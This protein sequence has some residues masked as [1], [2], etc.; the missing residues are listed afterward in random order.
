M[1]KYTCLLLLISLSILYPCILRSQD[2]TLDSL[3]KVLQ[4]QGE[5]TNRANTLHVISYHLLLQANFGEA[6]V[7]ATNELSL[8]KKLGFKKGMANASWITAAVYYNQS[9]YTEAINNALKSLEIKKELNDKR[10]T[11]LLYQMLS[12]AN[13][14]IGNYGENLQYSYESLRIQEE[15]K[16]KEGIAHQLTDLANT[17]TD[18][19]NYVEGKKNA[20]AGFKLSEEIKDTSSMIWSRGILSLIDFKDGKLNE[21]LDKRLI[22]IKI[23]EKM[24]SAEADYF[25]ADEYQYTGKIY[26]K[27]GDQAFDTGNE[28]V[29]AGYFA[30]AEKNYLLALKVNERN[31]YK[32]YIASVH[33]DLA[34]INIKFKKNQAAKEHLQQSLALSKA[35]GFKNVI[36]DSYRSLSILDSL[37]GNYKE[38]YTYYKLYILYRDSIHSTEGIGKSSE[39]KMQYALEKKEAESKIIQ[40]KKDAEAKLVRNIQYTAI[41]IFLLV[42]IFLYWNNHQKQK[43][44]TRIEQAYKEL[45]STQAQLIQSEKMASLGE[46]TAGIAHEIQNPLNFVNNFSEV[47]NELIDEMKTELINDNK[48]DAIAI[49]DDLKQNLEK[50]NHHGKRADAIV[51]GMLQH[52]RTSTG[53]KELTD[54]N[55]LADE[56]L[57]LAYHGL[58]AKDKSFNATSNTDFD[59]S[60]TADKTDIGKIN[61]I[62][63]DIGRVLLNLYNNAFYAALLPTPDGGESPGPNYKHEPTVWVSTK[64]IGDKVLISVKD[65]GPG[66]PQNIVDKIFQPFFT[67]K[68]TGQGTGLGLSLSYDIVKAHGGKIKVET[69]EGQGSEFIIEL[70]V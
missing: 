1:K 65:N 15:L 9:N 70:P 10:G 49:A 27:Q 6:L 29:A 32:D 69:K 45:K 58:R 19:G 60:L 66:I 47:S 35:T 64:K 57:R 2:K 20:L 31:N 52:S 13:G 11:A 54:I 51:K 36:R 26:E 55:A 33:V 34:N 4:N 56:Y 43:A 38:A 42:G 63:Q 25:L 67:T 22:N 48:E 62:P 40:T 68:P 3:K 8:A 17:Y 37:Q 28:K 5:D 50:I 53:H 44:K 30:E 61:I 7:Y 23:L 46:L 18:H 12:S 24:D 41:A 21:A 16:D 14:M 39:I 59:K